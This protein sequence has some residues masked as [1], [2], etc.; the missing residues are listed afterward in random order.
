MVATL[1]ETTGHRAHLRMW[2]AM[3]ST[4]EGRRILA[5]RPRINT[6]TLDMDLLDS[7]PPNTLGAAYMGFLRDNDV[8]P[9]SRCQVQFIEDEELR[10]VMQRYREVHDLF[11]T[12]L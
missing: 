11:H 2:D 10:Y 3:N 5:Q 12:V 1:G 4:E 8:T 6:S 9:D 7:A